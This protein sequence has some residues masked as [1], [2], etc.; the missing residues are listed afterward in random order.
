MI[1]SEVFTKGRRNH[2]H[3]LRFPARPSATFLS[4]SARL[5]AFPTRPVDPPGLYHKRRERLR[6]CSAPAAANRGV[7]GRVAATLTCNRRGTRYLLAHAP[8][9][10]A[11][12]ALRGRAVP[13]EPERLRA[14][15]ETGRHWSREPRDS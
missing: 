5:N 7:R 6:F 13:G 12:T 1:L 3:P 14:L 2:A 9:G 15:V 10:A 4:R 8:S 11:P